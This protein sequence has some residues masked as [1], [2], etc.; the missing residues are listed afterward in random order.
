MYLKSGSEQ[1]F[2]IFDDAPASGA[3]AS[4]AVLI[5]PPWGWEETASYRG[6]RL[7]AKRFAAQGHP[8]LRIDFPSTGNSFGAPGDSGR[9]RAWVAAVVDA[10]NWLLQASGRQRLSVVGLGLGGLVAIEAAGKG[11]PIDAVALWATPRNGR[12]FVR[13]AGSFAKLQAAGIGR[14]EETPLPD[15]WLEAGGF[16][17]SADALAE[18]KTLEPAAP[19]ELRRALL[20]GRD[21]IE[22]DADLRAKLEAGG[23]AVETAPGNGWNRF[24]G[25]TELPLD[26]VEEI[27]PLV[28]RLTAWLA[29]DAGT[30]SASGGPVLL[31]NA[32]PV[33]FEVGGGRARESCVEFDLQA[34]K[35][36]AILSEPLGGAGGDLCVVYL[37]AGGIR[38]IGPS[39][40]WVEAARRWAPRVASARID[41]E[42]IGEADGRPLPIPEIVADQYAGKYLEQLTRFLDEL[43]QRRLGTRFLLIGL[44]SGGYL[45]FQ[46]ALVDPRVEAGVMLNPG[47]LI[48]HPELKVE[49]RTRSA[50]KR[51]RQAESWK[52]LL[53]REVDLAPNLRLFAAAMQQK[54]CRRWNRVA[55]SALGSQLAAGGSQSLDELFDRLR[56]GEK[57]IAMSFCP[58]EPVLAE[59]ERDG[60]LARLGEWPNLEL[61]YL[62][63]ED[64]GLG[65]LVTQR[66]ANI[67]I[68]AEISRALDETASGP[69]EAGL[70]RPA[71]GG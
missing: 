20:L 31:P 56:D 28:D 68:D 4:A 27:S 44:C 49:R 26:V 61:G 9:L 29:E 10:S 30:E 16:V 2:A 67:L 62:D 50:G 11:A 1:I 25:L 39:R 48:W 6:R 37:N 24:S 69:A 63:G 51:I 46:S 66:S 19:P 8:T 53:R 7:L 47:A 14:G 12:R 65:P 58:N 35:G 13:E 41:L 5:C 64:H 22:A 45:S 42:G 57:R 32:A 54:L 17:L 59:L 38:H 43:E 36:L 70:G 33:E 34:G 21:G 18:I 40:V 71:S 15:G 55:G 3:P 23:V 60:F 52:R